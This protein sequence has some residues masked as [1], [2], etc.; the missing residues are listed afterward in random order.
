MRA[1]V[2]KKAR[3]PV[4][5]TQPKAKVPFCCVCDRKLHAGGRAYVE[6]TDPLGHKRPAH[7][8]CVEP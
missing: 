5:F 4:R 7:K 1:R 2:A 8:A 6:V 3:K